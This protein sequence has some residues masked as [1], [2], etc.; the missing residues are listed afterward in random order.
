MDCHITVGKP[1]QANELCKLG[2]KTK[3]RHKEI[4][5]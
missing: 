2:Q 3:D 1:V 5:L 4:S